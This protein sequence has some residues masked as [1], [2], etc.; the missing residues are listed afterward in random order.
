VPLEQKVMGVSRIAVRYRRYPLELSGPGRSRLN[1]VV[2]LHEDATAA[3]HIVLQ[4]LLSVVKQ[5]QKLE[6]G[7]H[8]FT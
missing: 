3:E 6:L 7:E 1:L 5:I 8:P 2:E 4:N